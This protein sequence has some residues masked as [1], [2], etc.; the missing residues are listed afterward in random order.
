M[1]NNRNFEMFYFI[2]NIRDEMSMKW[3]SITQGFSNE[4]SGKYYYFVY[5]KHIILFYKKLSSTLL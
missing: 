2:Q 4:N 5:F 3:K 1:I